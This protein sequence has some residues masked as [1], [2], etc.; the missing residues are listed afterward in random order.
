MPT[1]LL[2]WIW[3]YRLS[4]LLT[5]FFFKSLGTDLNY[6]PKKVKTLKSDDSE[7]DLD[8]HRQ[9]SILTI[10]VNPGTSQECHLLR[11]QSTFLNVYF[12]QKEIDINKTMEI[13]IG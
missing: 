6:T 10:S 7:N 11:G 4:A 3:T 12:C 1:D 2:I 9:G 8:I 5:F 13:N